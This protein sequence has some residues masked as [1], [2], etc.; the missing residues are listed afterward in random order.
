MNPDYQPPGEFR[1]KGSLLD[2]E[3]E[4]IENWK[5][6]LLSQNLITVTGD[7]WTNTS[8]VGC[9][10]IEAVTRHGAVHIRTVARTADVVEENADYIANIFK[11]NIQQL[12][13]VERVVGI[14]TD[15]ES[16]MRSVWEKLESDA[17]LKG[18]VAVPCAAHLC[19]LL[20]KDLAN[21][22]WIS[23]IIGNVKELVLHV[24]SHGHVLALFRSKATAHPTLQGK[25]LQMPC[26]TRFGT[27]FTMLE[28][29]F[30]MKVAL[31]EMVVDA[32][33]ESSRNYNKEIT[34]KILSDDF[35]AHVEQAIQLM[36]P[37]YSLLRFV[38]GNAQIGHVF[39]LVR[40]VGEKISKV[41]SNDANRAFQLFMER[42][43]G[44]TRKVAF[45]H[46]VHTLSMMLLP[47]NWDVDFA[48][49]YGEQYAN[50]RLEFTATLRKMSRTVLDAANA[51]VQYDQ[52]YRQ[53]QLPIFQDAL[54]V[55]SASIVDPV[56]WWECN[57][58]E[59]QELQ[60]VA[61][62][63]LSLACSN[64]A[65]ERNWSIH[66]FI[67]SKSRNRLSFDLQAKLVNLYSN[68]KLQERL[69]TKKSVQPVI[70]YMTDEEFG[71]HDEP[72]EAVRG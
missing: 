21:M 65:A 59:M 12:G 43:N 70:D 53:K 20:L 41:D 60:H 50:M 45:H 25:E 72:E 36:E 30:L 31:R 47:S 13:G 5:Q 26:V 48:Q 44:T 66:G 38:D 40:E 37:V 39:D 16:T 51:L 64:S 9:K 11:T 52:V 19:N 33:Y 29:T 67:H 6:Q 63:V 27:Y 22:N 55:A 49:K 3:T 62:R 4:Q 28:R 35:W 2:Q 57:G 18:L 61:K 24:K 1:L 23:T 58:H 32:S 14:C 56:T 69:L 42:L 71:L 10:N 46:P 17:D 8:G 54:V 34:R 15:N 68:L 7:G